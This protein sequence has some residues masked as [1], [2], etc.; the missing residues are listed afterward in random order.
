MCAVDWGPGSECGD[1]VHGGLQV[2]FGETGRTLYYVSR[3]LDFIIKS[4]GM[5]SSLS[6]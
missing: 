5:L 2:T 4:P 1:K 6:S 3:S